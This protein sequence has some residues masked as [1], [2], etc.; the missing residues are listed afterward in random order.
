[1]TTSIPPELRTLPRDEAGPVF[2]EPREA[3][4]LALAV[5]GK[6]KLSQ[7]RSAADQ[8]RVREA[9]AGSGDPLAAAVARLMAPRV[10]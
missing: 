10:P 5:E 7:N 3:Q 9:L 1:M 2:R 6:A 8:G 4:A